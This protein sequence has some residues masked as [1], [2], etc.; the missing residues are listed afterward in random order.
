[1]AER[2]NA[3][4]R[5]EEREDKHVAEADK[6]R[7]EKAEV[8]GQ[9]EPKTETAGAERDVE[10]ETARGGTSPDPQ[11]VKDRGEE[12]SNAKAAEDAKEIKTD[13]QGPG[14]KVLDRSVPSVAVGPNGEH[15]GADSGASAPQARRSNLASTSEEIDERA[16]LVARSVL[17]SVAPARAREEANAAR[18]R[19]GASDMEQAA[20]ELR[21]AELLDEVADRHEAAGELLTERSRLQSGRIS[22]LGRAGGIASGPLGRPL[23]GFVKRGEPVV[24]HQPEGQLDQFGF[25]T[26]LWPEVA[27]NPDDPKSRKRRWRADVVT[28]PLNSGSAAHAEGLSYGEGIGQFEHIKELDEDDEDAVAR[29]DHQDQPWRH[30]IR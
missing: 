6:A 4:A 14:G 5:A 13:D 18:V 19:A 1:M 28:F 2:K 12:S 26:R 9:D 10:G 27:D 17:P 21:L 7:E 23:P 3:R 16:D 20:V 11:F 24:V 30:E 15:E 29:R 8:N 22:Q 25:V